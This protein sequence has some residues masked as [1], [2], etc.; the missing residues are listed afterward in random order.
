[1]K[2]RNAKQY[3]CAIHGHHITCNLINKLPRY[4]E[5]ECALLCDSV[6]GLPVATTKLIRIRMI[7]HRKLQF[8]HCGSRYQVSLTTTIQ[9]S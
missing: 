4:A 8:P 7:H 1:M 2:E 6:E 3:V 5:S 9:N